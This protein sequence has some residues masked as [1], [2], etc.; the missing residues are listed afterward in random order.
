MTPPTTAPL[1]TEPEALT[2]PP[3][4][5]ARLDEIQRRY[6]PRLRELQ[7]DGEALERSLD[8]PSSVEAVFRADVDITWKDREIIL[9]VP[10][11]TVKDQVIGIDVPEVTSRNRRIVFD[12]PTLRMER[13][14]IAKNPLTGKCM[15]IS[16]PE[17]RM[18]RREIVTKIPKVAMR[19][20]D[21]ILGIPEVTMKPTRF[22]VK[23]PQVTVRNMR[24][25]AKKVEEAAQALEARAEQI[26]REME[27]EI[28]AAVTSFEAELFAGAGPRRREVERAFEEALQSVDAA[29][30]DVQA[31]GVDPIKVPA[32][33]G[34]VNLRKIYAEIV[35]K[36]KQA[37]TE[38]AVALDLDG[39]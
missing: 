30:K 26:G 31:S 29:I 1:A 6:E 5:Q 17:T 33:G 14:C 3:D 12:V 4:F 34:D 7:A 11:V 23:L 21:V 8:E 18:E 39:R 32:D 16:R 35:E 13:W 9:D 24:A 27:T 36:Q 37:T 2:T 20:R 10:Q 19:R 25:E 28:N 38:I 15:Y 22:V